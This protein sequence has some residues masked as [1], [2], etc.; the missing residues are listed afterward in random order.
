M[1]IYKK[2][3][4]SKLRFES[5]KGNL[6]TEQL[7]EL[8]ISDLDDM[9]RSLETQYKASGTKTFIPNV[10]K[11]PKD[12]ESKLKF[13]LVIDILETKV[14][15]REEATKSAETRIHNQKITDLIAQK[16]EGAMADLSIEELQNLMK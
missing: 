9:A 13:D 7:W 14:N 3:S 16:Q 11:S 10:K 1:D 15:D 8:S 2:A 12:T 5:S 4:K 6:T